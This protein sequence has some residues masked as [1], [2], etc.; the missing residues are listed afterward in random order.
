MQSLVR[1]LAIQPP[2]GS[3][4]F[5]RQV[6]TRRAAAPSFQHTPGV[7]SPHLFQYLDRT[8]ETRNLSPGRVLPAVSSS[9]DTSS[10][11]ARISSEGRLASACRR[12]GSQTSSELF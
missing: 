9:L 2:Q 5:A 6:S 12:A 3:L 8:D 10:S 1:L 7:R 11:S 4:C